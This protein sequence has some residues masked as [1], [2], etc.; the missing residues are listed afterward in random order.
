[1]AIG[2][3][4]VAGIWGPGPVHHQINRFC[5]LD[6]LSNVRRMTILRVAKLLGLSPRSCQ[7]NHQRPAP[8]QPSLRTNTVPVGA[9]DAFSFVRLAATD[10]ICFAIMLRHAECRAG[11]RTVI[12]ATQQYPSSPGSH[13]SSVQL[14]SNRVRE[15]YDFDTMDV[16]PVFPVSPRNDG[17]FPGVSPISSPSTLS[18]PRS[19]VT[20][21]TVSLLNKATGSFDSTAGSTVTSLSITDY[22]GSR[23][24][25]A[26]ACTGPGA[27]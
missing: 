7:T 19:L 9:T 14:Y 8:R 5:C 12:I 13:L 2:C 10:L 23:G 6:M 4:D 15:D 26:S 17:Y 21:A 11:Y 24:Y 3:P 25:V 22:A 1:M 20:P 27:A 18:T 16:F